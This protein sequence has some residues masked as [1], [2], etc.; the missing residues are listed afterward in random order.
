MLVLQISCD[1]FAT[2]AFA[3]WMRTGSLKG[4]TIRQ[5]AWCVKKQK[6][7]RAISKQIMDSMWIRS[8]SRWCSC[9]AIKKLKKFVFFL[10]ILFSLNAIFGRLLTYVVY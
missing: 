5:A 3:S 4:L 9:N 2:A 10:C 8:A 7:H 6:G 1:A